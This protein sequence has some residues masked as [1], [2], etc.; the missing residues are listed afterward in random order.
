M[1]PVTE[2]STLGKAVKRAVVGEIRS[3]GTSGMASGGQLET[4]Y[5]FSR[6]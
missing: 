5:G 2:K 4:A 3:V 6:R 1:G